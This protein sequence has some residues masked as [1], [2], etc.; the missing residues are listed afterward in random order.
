MSNRRS[1]SSELSACFVA[2]TEPEQRCYYVPEM[3]VEEALLLKCFDSE[4]NRVRFTGHSAFDD[5]T[6]AADAPPRES[7]EVRVLA[8][9]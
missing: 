1:T 4:R 7:I 9:F 2:V 3:R 6:S 5:P 8:F